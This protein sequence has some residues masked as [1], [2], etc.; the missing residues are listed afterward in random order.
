MPQNKLF[1]L[2]L[3]SILVAGYP[4]KSSADWRKYVPDIAKKYIPSDGTEE[5]WEDGWEEDKE[6]IEDDWEEAEEEIE[7]DWEKYIPNFDKSK[8][9]KRSQKNAHS[10][11]GPTSL[12]NKSLTNLRVMGP[13]SLKDST[14]KGK[15]DVY[16]PFKGNSIQAAKL[17][18]Q[19]PT[20]IYNKSKLGSVSING[21]LTIKNSRVSSDLIVNGPIFASHSVFMGK[22]SVSSTKLTFKDCNLQTLKIRPAHSFGNNQQVLYLKGNTIVN[23]D[24]SFMTGNGKIIKDASVVIK[25]NIYGSK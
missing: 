11:Y 17:T 14:I 2:I 20:S 7:N 10:Y 9:S 5:E 22:I 15:L 6:E 21:P 16:G 1:L 23:G 8:A 19:G 13:L 25:G 4:F 12:S 18:V 3:S 24:I